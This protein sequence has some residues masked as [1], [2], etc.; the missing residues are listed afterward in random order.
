MGVFVKRLHGM[1]DQQ[2][3]GQQYLELPGAISDPNRN[4]HKELHHQMA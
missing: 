2:R 3:V 1:P 4:H